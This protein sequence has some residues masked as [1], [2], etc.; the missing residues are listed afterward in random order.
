MTVHDS[1]AYYA[2]LD[3]KS[4]DSPAVASFVAWPKSPFIEYEHVK[5]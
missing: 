1:L 5:G 2:V 4:K 3:E